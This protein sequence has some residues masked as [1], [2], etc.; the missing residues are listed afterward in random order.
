M[1]ILLTNN[2]LSARAGSEM[3]AYDV[4]CQLKR[5]GHQPVAYSPDL[6]EVAELLRSAGVP[7]VSRLTGLDFRPDVIHG[8]HHVETMTALACFPGVPAVSFCHG[9]TP[10]QEMPPRFPRI[11]RYV[12]VD[13]ACRDRIVREANVPVEQVQM[14]LNFAD[15]DRFLPRKPLPDK[16]ARALLLSNTAKHVDHAAADNYAAIV[17]AACLSRGISLDVHGSTCGNPTSHPENLFHNYDLVFAKGRTAIEAMAVGCAVVLCDLAGCGSMVTAAT[18]DNLRPLNFGLQSLRLV[19]TVDTIA[20]AI[21]HY[22]PTD[23]A[24]VRDR[25]RQEARLTDTVTTLVHLYEAVMNEQALRPA[26]PTAELLATGAY[27][28]TLDCILK[29]QNIASQPQ[30]EPE[31]DN[32]AHMNRSSIWH[33]L[34]RQIWP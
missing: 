1:R 4:A 21:D 11:L 32:P 5:L 12:A 20:A 23:A 31:P 28:Q 13:L 34:L 10:W 8:H 6:G 27:L 3:Y 24:R 2:T 22:S 7:V 15:M 18:F 30:Q 26:D 14:L 25:I 16:P 29:G 9:S 33:R 17:R 19:N